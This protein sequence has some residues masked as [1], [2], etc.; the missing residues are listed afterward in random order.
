MDALAAQE[1]LKSAISTEEGWRQLLAWAEEAPRSP[2]E[3]GLVLQRRGTVLAYRDDL[4]GSRRAYLS[5]ARAW[6]DAPD[7]QEEAAT[8]LFS[9]DRARFF[10]GDPSERGENL[11]VAANLRGR[12]QSS[13][14]TADRLT[15]AGLHNLIDGK[16]RQALLR[17]LKSRRVSHRSG[18]L[19]GLIES[20]HTLSRVWQA[21][22]EE[23]CDDDDRARALHYSIRAG[24]HKRAEQ[25]GGQGGC[26]QLPPLLRLEGSRWERAASYAAVARCGRGIPEPEYSKIAAKV[27]T[28]GAGKPASSFGN[29]VVRLARRATAACVF[30][31]DAE[32]RE[33]VIA[34][35]A[36]S[37]GE[38]LLDD[39]H[40]ALVALRQ[41]QEAGLA[42]H[43]DLLL[44][45]Y[46]SDTPSDA[47]R[48]YTAQQLFDD[49]ASQETMWK[50]GLDGR[51]RALE[52]LVIA[53]GVRDPDLLDLCELAVMAV[54]DLE[55]HAPGRLDVVQLSSEGLFGTVVD[56]RLRKR[57]SEKLTALATDATDSHANRMEALGALFTL[58]PA[59]DA[60]TSADAFNAIAPAA[61]GNAPA[62]G[63]DEEAD[64]SRH[65][66]AMMRLFEPR[67]D[68]HVALAIRAGGALAKNIS[69]PQELQE[70]VDTALSQLSTVIRSAALEVLTDHPSL[71]A[72]ERMVQSEDPRMLASQLRLQIAR[73]GMPSLEDLAAVFASPHF[74][75]RVALLQAA[76]GEPRHSEVLERLT[77][78]PDGYLRAIARRHLAAQEGT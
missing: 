47:V 55:T 49:E 54:L 58:A 18:D 5:A 43:R 14:A 2:Q 34:L 39:R 64:A 24:E 31:E 6:A 10:L 19:S 56:P 75:P 13:A 3:R 12:T 28:E 25:L 61:V 35:L 9:S 40:R 57:L 17:A 16:L 63:W 74:E 46:L 72:P 15:L 52:A 36:V 30:I 21:I 70:I 59:L 26:G 37:S 71:K 60:A 20:F 29:D 23:S 45:D 68:Q 38:G 50:A 48:P 53:G 67:R 41:A 1:A 69:R 22:A 33:R 11:A 77:R 42:D 8:A 76:S 44:E 65:P 27:V 62:S 51:R 32:V 7:E 4:E 78:D 66:L 73:K